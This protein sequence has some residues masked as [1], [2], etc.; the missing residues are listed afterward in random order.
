MAKRLRGGKEIPDTPN[1]KKTRLEQEEDILA[2]TSK[3]YDL[4]PGYKEAQEQ[5]EKEKKVHFKEKKEKPTRKSFLEKALAKEYPEAK[6]RV[7]QRMV[8]EG[9]MELSYGEIVTISNGVTESFKN[10]VLIDPTAYKQTSTADFESDNDSEEE[11]GDAESPKR[12][13]YACPLG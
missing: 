8:S 13:H 4:F 3:D 1:A 5:I 2:I 12:S 7:V 6:D 11:D 9:R 10:K